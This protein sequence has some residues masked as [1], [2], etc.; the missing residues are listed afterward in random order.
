MLSSITTL[1]HTSSIRKQAEIEGQK[2][3]ERKWAVCVCASPFHV[4]RQVL[5][6]SRV[7]SSSQLSTVNYRRSLIN[8]NPLSHPLS[9]IQSLHIIMKFQ[10]LFCRRFKI[11]ELERMMMFDYVGPCHTTQPFSKYWGMTSQD[12]ANMMPLGAAML[13]HPISS[14]K[15]T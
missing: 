5:R 11:R 4:K 14:L 15:V 8:N 12:E 3:E 9:F 1:P 13:L 2:N 6:T 7:V 10:E